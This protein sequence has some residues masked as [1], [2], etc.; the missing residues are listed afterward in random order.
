MSQ[1]KNTNANCCLIALPMPKKFKKSKE[2]FDNT[3]Y[4]HW[5]CMCGDAHVRTY[6]QSTPGTFYCA[7]CYASLCIEEDRHNNYEAEFNF[8]LKTFYL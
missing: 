1:R 8:F 2:V 3:K 5:K 7:E 6:L 4:N